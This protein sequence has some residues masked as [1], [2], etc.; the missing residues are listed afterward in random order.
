MICGCTTIIGVIKHRLNVCEGH[1]I[2]EFIQEHTDYTI[3][4]TWQFQKYIQKN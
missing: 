1:R 3:D 2:V 4:N